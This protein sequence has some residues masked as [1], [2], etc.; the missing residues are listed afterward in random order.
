MATLSV[1]DRYLGIAPVVITSPTP[2][3]GTTLVQR[4]LTRSANA[5]IYG[6]EVGHQLRTTTTWLIGLLRQFEQTY[7]TIDP[8]FDKALAGTLTDWRPGLT[9]PTEIMRR[10]WI[11]TYYQ[12][13][14]ALSEFSARVG[15]P[16]WGFKVPGYNRDMLRA[17]FSL[18]PRTRVVYLIR[19][20]HDV[21]KS[22]KAR[23]FVT[24]DE[25]IRQFCADWAR[26]I[27]EVAELAADQRLIFLKYEDLLARR[28][29][30][31][32]LLEMFTGVEGADPA[33][34]DLK[35]NTFVGF[36]AQGHS[37]TQYIAPAELTEADLAAVE[38]E[39]GPV[40]AHFYGGQLA[41]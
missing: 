23:R 21:L 16:V 27:L 40:V 33:Q 11:E 9:A 7:P 41:A 17:V 8:D 28:D 10:A 32:R 5:F 36:E 4:L 24:T 2:R 20:L 31:L 19:N 18:M 26:N 39:A 1:P 30:H 29:E 37:P 12:L 13:P 35:I 15:R 22:A 38:A 34:F 6:E 3:C 25:D 14:F